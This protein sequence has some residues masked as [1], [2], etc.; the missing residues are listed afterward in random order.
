MNEKAI[1]L[2]REAREATVR[3]WQAHHR[4]DE[5][6]FELAY[7]DAYSL[8]TQLDVG[9]YAEPPDPTIQER[10]DKGEPFVIAVNDKPVT[11]V[12]PGPRPIA[13]TCDV[14]G[15]SLPQPMRPIPNSPDPSL[16]WCRFCE[17]EASR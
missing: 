12:K 1:K 14:C 8:L 7:K 15:G 16:V 9:L 10:M 6:E 4:K 17:W 5:R 3:M 2:G 13:P 11:L